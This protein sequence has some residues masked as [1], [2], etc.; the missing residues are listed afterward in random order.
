MKKSHLALALTLS[1]AFSLLPG[2]ASAQT[3]LTMYGIADLGLNFE[4][5]AAA[6]NAIKLSSGIQS[7]SRLGFRGTE[8]LGGGLS[9]KFALETGIAMDTGGFNQGNLAFGRQ[10]WVGLSGN[11][12]TFSMGRQYTPHY[13]ALLDIDPF[14]AGLSG[15]AQNLIV[16][17]TRMSNSL[18]YSSPSWSGFNGEL[19][20]GL[21][22][23]T[24][25]NSANR[26]YGASIGYA[27]GP[28]IVKL[29]HHSIDDALGNERSYDTILGGSWNFGVATLNLGA[30]RFRGFAGVDTRDYLIG[31]S[32]AFGPSTVLLSFIRKDDRTALNRDAHQ[33]ALGYTY[34]ISKRTNF[35]TSFGRISNDNGAGYTVNTAIETG[36]GDEA[37]N[38]GIR[39]AF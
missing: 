2:A 36:T 19:A 4:R 16:S 27:N 35:Y 21:G 14:K 15:N 34:A 13:L 17:P 12:G 22:E 37:F 28:V 25:N 32:A 23:V 8:D 30:N 29:A 38:F 9:A 20:Y 3:S 33:W 24:G 7:G 1:G 11:F 39:H 31:G 6:G 18:R 10:A 5:G 26:Q